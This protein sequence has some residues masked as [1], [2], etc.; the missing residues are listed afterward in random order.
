MSTVDSDE[1]LEQSWQAVVAKLKGRFDKKMDPKSVLFILGMQELGQVKNKFTKEQKLDL[2][3]IAFCRVC[4][5]SGYFTLEKIDEEGWPLWKQAKA[6]PK[7]STKEQ[8]RFIKSHVVKYFES[9][10]LI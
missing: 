6:L 7:M 2:M 10:E 1:A 5:L 4:S 3:N 8:E 9:Q